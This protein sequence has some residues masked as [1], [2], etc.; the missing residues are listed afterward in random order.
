MKQRKLWKKVVS[1]MLASIMA[2]SCLS[3]CGEQNQEESKTPSSQE[4]TEV[5]QPTSESKEPELELGY[6]IKEDVTLTIA[7]QV[8]AAVTAHAADLSETA[9]G[10]AWQEATGVNIEIVSY[11]DASA[12][13]MLLSSGDLPDIIYGNLNSYPGRAAGAIADGLI[14]PIN[15]YM[16]YAPDLQAVFDSS[17]DVYKNSM[18]GSGE[19]IGFPHVRPGELTD[20]TL[21]GMLIRKDWLDDLNMEVPTDAEEL[22]NVLKAFKEEKGAEYP[23]TGTGAMIDRLTSMGII[24]SPFNL[25]M[26]DFHQV[27]GTIQ[28]GYYEDEMKDVLAFMNKLV[29]EE[30]LNPNY[31]TLDNNAVTADMLNGVSGMAMAQGSRAYVWYNGGQEVDPEYDIVGVPS[32][33]TP[34][35]QFGMGA[36]YDK[37]ISGNC[38]FITT[39]CENIEAAVRFLNWG[40][41]DEGVLLFHSGIEGITYEIND[42]GYMV[43]LDGTS[44]HPEWT[45]AE[46]NGYYNRGWSHGPYVMREIYPEQIDENT[47]RMNATKEEFAKTRVRDY[48]IPTL[49]N[50]MTY[51]EAQEISKLMAEIKTYR[52]EMVTKFIL[53]TESL[54]NFEEY[55]K[56]LKEMGIERVIEIYQEAY[57]KFDSNK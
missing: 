41:T 6:P 54:D 15:D 44:K 13:N 28:Y 27:D 9:F 45:S 48:A 30:L 22:Y 38:A 53:G 23:L 24:T 31:A 7:W 35:G 12:L 20:A 18:T 25:P 16:Q 37:R 21:N 51:E 36:S 3:G 29:G 47:A 33:Q 1:C 34:D 14:Q 42:D 4:K 10:K 32:L 43:I 40:Y 56:A 5:S 17:E 55:Q 50:F 19:I 8:E 2:V 52:S 26:A 49:Q 11:A 46:V 57:N 39:D